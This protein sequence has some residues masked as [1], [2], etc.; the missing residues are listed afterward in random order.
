MFCPNCGCSNLSQYPAN[1][2][3]ADFFCV[4]CGDDFELKSQSKAFGRKVADGAY[5]TKIDRLSSNNAPNLILLQYDKLD[6]V[7]L[8]LSVIPKFFFV[9]E[10]V[11]ARKPLSASARRAGWIGSNILLE[12]IPLSGRIPVVKDGKVLDRSVILEEWC[13][14]RFLERRAVK[15]RGW[16]LEVM[17]CLE[18]I[19][20]DE[21]SIADVY[22]F[23]E[24]LKSAYPDNNNIRPKIRQQLQILRDN[25]VLDFLGGGRYRKRILLH[26]R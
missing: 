23:E 15:G 13:S 11:E 26:E 2:P 14:L 22:K 21:F 4:E 19:G 6:R 9:P 18:R 16:L 3:V 20:A 17:N 25:G 8:N 12:K 24:H 1:R 7:V 5:S 10:V